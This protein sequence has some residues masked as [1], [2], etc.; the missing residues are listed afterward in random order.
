MEAVEAQQLA[1][2]YDLVVR[3]LQGHDDAAALLED[4][5]DGTGEGDV[6]DAQPVRL[7]DANVFSHF[8]VNLN[9]E[10]YI[11]LKQQDSARAAVIRVQFDVVLALWLLRHRQRSAVNTSRPA[12]ISECICRINIIGAVDETTRLQ[13]RSLGRFMSSRQRVLFKLL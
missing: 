10:R 6:H 7:V 9:E 13:I 12:V 8:Q 4:A 11:V 2:V 3:L 5:V 1:A